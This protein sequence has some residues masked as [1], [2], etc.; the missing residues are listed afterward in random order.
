MTLHPG[1]FQ[2]KYLKE[3]VAKMATALVNGVKIHY[4]RRLRGFPLILRSGR[5]YYWMVVTDS[6][7]VA[8]LPAR[9]LG[10]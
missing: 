6:S 3:I 4:E 9:P 8:T 7:L 5:E 1:V 10:S 2:H